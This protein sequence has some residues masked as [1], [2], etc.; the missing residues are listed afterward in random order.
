M[1]FVLSEKAVLSAA[2]AMA[3]VAGS[4]FWTGAVGRA[5]AAPAVTETKANAHPYILMVFNNPVA[6]KEAEYNEWYNHLHAGEVTS[7][8]GFDHAQRFVASPTPLGGET[9]RRYVVLYYGQS[10]NL[11]QSYADYFVK[12]KNAPRGPE[13]ID[14][15]TNYND[16]FA[17]IGGEIA[18][19]AARNIESKNA[20]TYLWYVYA[21][22]VAEKDVA[23]E[24]WFDRDFARAI[25][26]TTGIVSAQAYVRTAEQLGNAPRV[27]APS[28]LILFKITTDD[29][30][31]VMKAAERTKAKLGRQ[32]A[33]PA[34]W[35]SYGFQALGPQVPA[36][37]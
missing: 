15:T 29:I 27:A 22:P 31:G 2:V 10:G 32:V 25:A 17:A 3:A 30:A 18:G 6:G 23:F 8:L 35:V 13:M 36:A 37:Q 7:Q 16:S 1:K 12:S 4:F 33:D 11:A 34:S 14:H 20:K 21:N 28:H 5:E 26:K 24:K 9:P 19:S